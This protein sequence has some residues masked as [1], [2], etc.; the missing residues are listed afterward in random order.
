[1]ERTWTAKPAMVGC[2]TAT[3]E[4]R[5]TASFRDAELSGWSARSASYDQHLA[6][7]T[8]QVVAPVM[9]LLESVVGKKVLDVCCG[10]GHLAGA[11]AASGAVVVGIDFAAPM[12]ARARENYP[13]LAFR[14]GDAEAL[15]YAEGAF[16]HV[17]CAFGVMHL[18]H[19][20]TAIAEAFRVLKQRG[21]YV[22]TQW[23]KDDELLGI[24]STAIAEHGAPLSMPDA[25][26]PMRFSDSLECR[27]VIEKSGF[28]EVRVD[29]VE[30]TCTLQ[31]PEA[32]LDLIY[33]GAVRAAMVLES[34]EPARRARIHDVIIDAA[35]RRLSEDRI[36]IRRPVVMASG[37]KPGQ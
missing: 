18:S 8:N 26:P 5:M 4:G 12:V 10:P 1:M 22:F 16:D 31:K 37:V 3:R 20:E 33:G 6:P 30:T 24:V 34:Q 9:A 28:I 19:P 35:K 29:R 14:Q 13:K 32:L 17:V 25:P 7:V 11:I 27:R 15:A 21:R 2:V 23:A 36:I